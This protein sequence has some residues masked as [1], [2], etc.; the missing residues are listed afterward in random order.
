MTVNLLY[1]YSQMM[2][3]RNPFDVDTLINHRLFFFVNIEI[4]GNFSA[5]SGN[6]PYILYHV[7]RDPRS[8]HVRNVV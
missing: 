7:G 5:R 3:T 1:F 2:S 4:N 6:E 8:R